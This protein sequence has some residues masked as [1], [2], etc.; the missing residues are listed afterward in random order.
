M[1]QC[2]SR[3]GGVPSL[4]PFATIRQLARGRRSGGCVQ[5][6]MD[7]HNTQ[8]AGCPGCRMCSLWRMSPESAGRLSSPASAGSLLQAPHGQRCAGGRLSL[9][10]RVQAVVYECG[11]WTGCTQCKEAAAGS[12]ATQQPCPQAASQR[13]SCLA[14]QS[15]GAA[16]ESRWQ[17]MRVPHLLPGRRRAG[18]KARRQMRV[19]VGKS[20]RGLAVADMMTRLLLK[21]HQIQQ[22]VQPPQ[23]HGAGPSLPRVADCGMQL[24]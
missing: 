8:P 19:R 11:P 3:S 7:S 15:S 20:G 14:P 4:D 21:I 17:Q 18:A 2:A 6:L 22:S 10:K 1:E 5:P 23:L 9:L 16:L 24:M 12:D 13:V